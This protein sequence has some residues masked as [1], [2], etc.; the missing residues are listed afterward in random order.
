MEGNEIHSVVA[1]SDILYPT[2]EDILQLKLEKHH[3]VG[4]N[5]YF[6]LILLL[7]CW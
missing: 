6:T 4:A 2:T 3:N 5:Y 1:Y 7:G